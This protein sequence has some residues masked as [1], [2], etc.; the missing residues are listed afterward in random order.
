M[1]M[2]MLRT[3]QCVYI[4]KDA[5]YQSFQQLQ[6][7]KNIAHEQQMTAEMNQDNALNWGMWGPGYSHTITHNFPQCGTVR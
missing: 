7:Q 3:C 4:G 5:N 1:F 2:R 6:V